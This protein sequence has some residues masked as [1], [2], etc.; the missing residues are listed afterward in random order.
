MDVV[1]AVYPTERNAQLAAQAIRRESNCSVDVLYPGTALERLFELPTADDMPPV[2]QYLTMTL[3][4]ALGLGLGAA[5]FLVLPDVPIALGIVAA[6]VLGMIGAVALRSAGRGVD[7]SALEGL[8]AD[9]LFVY[10]DALR[11]GRS[12]V[13]VRIAEPS[14]RAQIRKLLDSAQPEGIDPAR[15]L[16][17]VGLGS[18]EDLRYDPPASDLKEARVRTPQEPVR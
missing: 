7:R 10:K 16:I 1:T 4:A 11:K 15:G 14:K 18:A 3:G 13:I 17:A 5:A 8:P 2:A 12:V 9:E 6:I